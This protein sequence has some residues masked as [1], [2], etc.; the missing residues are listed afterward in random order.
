[1]N[2]GHPR[3]DVT[4]QLEKNNEEGLCPE[5]GLG[6]QRVSH[7]LPRKEYDCVTKKS[8]R[9]GLSVNSD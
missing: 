8:G 2:N 1:M 5:Y 9:A 3:I 7:E 4:V 6:K